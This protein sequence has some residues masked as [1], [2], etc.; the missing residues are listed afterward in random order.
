MRNKFGED[1]GGGERVSAKA[2]EILC[3]NVSRVF[4]SSFIALVTQLCLTLCNPV[5]HRPP[6]SFVL[7]ISQARILEWVAISFSRG[8]SQPRN[9]TWI[10]HVAVR[11]F[12]VLTTRESWES[13]KWPQNYGQLSGLQC[14]RI[15]QRSL[16]QLS[17]EHTCLILGTGT[18][19]IENIQV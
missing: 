19:A 11:F 7:E 1:V 13:S 15:M 2:W 14:A 18:L 10:S 5:D 12:V 17:F 9:W 3:I 16:I 8:S 4:H 6:G